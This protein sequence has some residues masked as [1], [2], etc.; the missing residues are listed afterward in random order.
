MT[1]VDSNGHKWPRIPING[2]IN[3]TVIEHFFRTLLYLAVC[4]VKRIIEY[5]NML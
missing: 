2:Q 3:S 1:Q 5:P 4:P